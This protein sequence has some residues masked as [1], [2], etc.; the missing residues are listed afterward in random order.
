MSPSLY[1]GRR[2]GGVFRPWNIA[3]RKNCAEGWNEEIDGARNAKAEGGRGRR[4]IAR[5]N[6]RVSCPAVRVTSA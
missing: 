5:G 2:N 6:S 1:L 3:E 4:L